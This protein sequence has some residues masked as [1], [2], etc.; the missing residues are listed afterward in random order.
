MAGRHQPT[1]GADSARY[2]DTLDIG[3]AKC[4]ATYS[5]METHRCAQDLADAIALLENAGFYVYPSS[6]APIVP[7]CIACSEPARPNDIYCRTHRVRVQE[8]D[9][10]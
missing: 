10:L 2:T 4:G 6:P 3:C 7:R 1:H 9:A 5:A 8:E